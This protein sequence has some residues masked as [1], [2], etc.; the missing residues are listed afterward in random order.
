MLASI[1]LYLLVVATD[2]F[3]IEEIQ[4]TLSISN[5]T[6]IKPYSNFVLVINEDKIKLYQDKLQFKWE[7]SNQE[8]KY[9]NIQFEFDTI[10]ALNK[11]NHIHKI[12][13][14]SGVK[15]DM[16][17]A[18]KIDYYQ[19]KYPYM[20]AKTKKNKIFLYNLNK[21]RIIWEKALSCN[22]LFF[23]SENELIGCINKKKLRVYS[24]LSGKPYYQTSHINSKWDFDSN[25][26]NGGYFS[27]KNSIILFDANEKKLR[28]FPIKQRSI[29]AVIR[30]KER[31]IID[32]TEKTLSCI[33]II[34]NKLRWVHPYEDAIDIILNDTN[35]ILV[36]NNKNYRL[37]DHYSGELLGEFSLTDHDLEFQ[38]M[39]SYNNNV[40]FI[41]NNKTYLLDRK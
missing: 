7:I 34:S 29:K 16:N 15:E 24:T 26:N 4:T 13:L 28:K 38:A 6:K 23:L 36:K 30:Q 1:I 8:N 40:Y 18:Q 11:D 31:V 5:K 9:H 12:T 19:V 37:I 14:K 33:D 27:N 22:Q 32:P 20:W 25:D 21:D 39:Y 35:T 41:I 10:Y 2:I 3:A 17:I